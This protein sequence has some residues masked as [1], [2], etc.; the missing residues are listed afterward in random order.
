MA[1]PA[2]PATPATPAAPDAASA[3][4]KYT[5]DMPSLTNP[6]FKPKLSKKTP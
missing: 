5:I 4:K 2:T 1:E 6:L 3:G